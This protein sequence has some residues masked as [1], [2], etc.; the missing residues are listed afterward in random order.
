MEPHS[1]DNPGA[2]QSPV[3]HRDF[4]QERVNGLAGAAPATH[5][6]SNQG[7]PL[8]NFPIFYQGKTP[9]C[10]AHSTAWAYIYKYWLTNKQQYPTLLSPRFLYALCKAN[11]GVPNVEGTYPRTAVN[12]LQKYGISPDS[13]YTNDVTLPLS[14]YQSTSLITPTAYTAAKPISGDTYISVALDVDS[15]KAAIDQYGSVLMCLS[16]DGQWWSAPNGTASWAADDVLPVR[17]PATIVSGHQVCIYGYDEKYLYFANSFGTAWGVN[18]Y[19]WL[20]PTAYKPWFKECWAITELTPE[21][22]QALQQAA[23]VLEEQ[24]PQNTVAEAWIQALLAW[25]QNL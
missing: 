16:L 5:A 9:A 23:Q 2:V 25:L 22:I 10:V 11:D 13:D 18:G 7:A 21:V 1:F 8:I 6:T 17:P 12:M 15:I 4:T 24:K 20:D 19:G 3:D 14:T